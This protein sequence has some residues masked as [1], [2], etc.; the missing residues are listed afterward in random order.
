MYQFF[1]IL[2]ML[3]ILA[4]AFIF[5]CAVS[6]PKTEYEQKMDDDEQARWLNER[7]NK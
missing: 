6:I 5:Y 1:A 7:Y 3:V 2:G 4:N